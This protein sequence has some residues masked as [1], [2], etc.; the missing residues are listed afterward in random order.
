[1]LNANTI[2]T[3]AEQYNSLILEKTLV[4]RAQSDPR[5]LQFFPSSELT[6]HRL[7]PGTKPTFTHS[8]IRHG[9]L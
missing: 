9:R 4:D 2:E 8:A 1:V 7:A 3:T 5:F 6:A